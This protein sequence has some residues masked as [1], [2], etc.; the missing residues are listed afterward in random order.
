MVH[1]YSTS[2]AW[3]HLEIG[4]TLELQGTGTY[5]DNILGTFKQVTL[6]TEHMLASNVEGAN[7]W[8]IMDHMDAQEIKA[9]NFHVIESHN[10]HLHEQRSKQR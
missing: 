10:F 4:V 2:S 6:N 1:G 5:I 7:G 8:D 3:Q 9:C